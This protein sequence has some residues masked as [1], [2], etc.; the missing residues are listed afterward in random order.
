MSKPKNMT[1]EQEAEWRAKER[2]RQSERLKC[3]LNREKRRASSRASKAKM[4][5]INPEKRRDKEREQYAKDPEK[6]REKQRV[7]YAKNSKRYLDINKKW[8]TENR[9][10]RNEMER[11]WNAKNSEKVRIRYQNMRTSLSVCY[12]AGRLGIPTFIARQYPE[13]IEAKREQIKIIREL[14]P[15]TRKQTKCTRIQAI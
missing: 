11:K 7:K 5:A 9:E 15:T 6:F 4:K 1:P 12:V 10:R 2:H 14:K 8:R 3:P 13:L